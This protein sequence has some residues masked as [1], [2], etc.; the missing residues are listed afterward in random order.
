MV[1]LAAA[2]SGCTGQAVEKITEQGQVSLSDDIIF[3]N[4]V[5]EAS[6]L[7]SASL[8]LSSGALGRKEYSTFNDYAKQTE[9]D[10]TKY[11]QR[12]NNLTVSAQNQDMY[13]EFHLYL[14]NIRDAAIAEQQA[15]DFLQNDDVDNYVLF[16]NIAANH[17]EKA[18]NHIQRATA[19][20]R[21]AS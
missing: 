4:T 1:L 21:Y 7:M 5:K 20:L 2:L 13:N 8:D 10:A 11:I 3:H 18:N 19:Y 17:L 15:V 6:A 14:E 12:L 16:L 9:G